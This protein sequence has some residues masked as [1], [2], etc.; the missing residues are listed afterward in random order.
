MGRDDYDEDRL[1]A[2]LRTRRRRVGRE[3]GGV[4]GGEEQGIFPGE[5]VAV[6]EGTEAT[7]PGVAEVLLAGLVGGVA[8]EGATAEGTRG[9]DAAPAV[10]EEAAVAL[11][12]EAG[13]A[14]AGDDEG[15][16][17]VAG[18]ELVVV[19][20]EVAA[21]AAGAALEAEL[22]EMAVELAVESQEVGDGVA[23]R[24]EGR[25]GVSD[26]MHASALG[27]KDGAPLR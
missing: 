21:P 20:L 19:A 5:A 6:G 24:W 11:G 16:L 26:R 27:V 10:N 23:W 13:Q 8:E 12:G 7:L 14:V 18:V 2:G 1:K 3:E 9:V 22:G 15:S 17:D 25:Q 4:E